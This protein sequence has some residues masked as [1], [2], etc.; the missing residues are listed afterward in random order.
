MAASGEAAVTGLPA[1]LRTQATLEPKLQRQTALPGLCAVSTAI[2]V[3]VTTDGIQTRSGINTRR[4]VIDF[5]DVD[6]IVGG[7][8]C[9]PDGA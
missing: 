2:Q 3:L 1:A 4:E 6:H 5:Q 7:G 9:G 8:R